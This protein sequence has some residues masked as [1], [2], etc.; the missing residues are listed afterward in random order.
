MLFF[1]FYF[2]KNNKNKHKNI[3]QIPHHHTVPFRAP[4][5][6]NP[7]RRSGL[8]CWMNYQMGS[9]NGSETYGTTTRP[10]SSIGSHNSSWANSHYHAFVRLMSHDVG[11]PSPCPSDHP[12]NSAS[13]S[14]SESSSS[15][16]SQEDDISIVTGK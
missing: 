2:K 8:G 7:R 12:F 4:P 11:P 6:Y 10:T 14:L 16:R 13:S 5:R 9:S 15:H 1:I 3:N